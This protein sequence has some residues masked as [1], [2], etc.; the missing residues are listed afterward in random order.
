[1]SCGDSC[2]QKSSEKFWE[3]QAKID[4]LKSGIDLIKASYDLKLYGSVKTLAMHYFEDYSTEYRL[5]SKMSNK[6]IEMSKNNVIRLSE[7][8]LEGAE[9]DLEQK[10]KSFI[11]LCKQ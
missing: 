4:N 10:K 1:M 7:I 5:V 2:E 3:E 9:L 8:I 11:E 6:N